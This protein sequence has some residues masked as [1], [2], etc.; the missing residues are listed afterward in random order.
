[1]PRIVL[2]FILHFVAQKPSRVKGKSTELTKGETTSGRKST[3][4]RGNRSKA[5]SEQDAHASDENQENRDLSLEIQLIPERV[6]EKN[7]KRGST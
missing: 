2:R 7:E 5:D 6:R 1:M 3:E 4:R